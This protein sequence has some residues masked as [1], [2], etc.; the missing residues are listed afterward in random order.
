MQKSHSCRDSGSVVL[1]KLSLIGDSTPDDEDD[2]SLFNGE[3]D[4]NI[5]YSLDTSG[6]TSRLIDF[7]LWFDLGECKLLVEWIDEERLWGRILAD[8]LDMGEDGDDEYE[9]DELGLGM[10]GMM[11]TREECS[12]CFL[13][14]GLSYSDSTDFTYC[15]GL[16]SWWFNEERARRKLIFDCWFSWLRW[17]W[18]WWPF[19][20]PFFRLWELSLDD[21]LSK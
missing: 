15:F 14:L 6:W 17:C 3:G 8:L 19:E 4:F 10:P 11:H 13:F 9:E 20:N 18:P 21:D 12:R 7:G 1:I 5:L 16:A 2:Q